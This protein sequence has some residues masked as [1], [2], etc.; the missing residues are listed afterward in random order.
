M[1][2]SHDLNKAKGLGQDLG[3]QDRV[4]KIEEVVETLMD[5][6]RGEWRVFDEEQKKGGKRSVGG[7]YM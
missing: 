6:V 5:D 4:R 2:I 1:A 3:A 7:V